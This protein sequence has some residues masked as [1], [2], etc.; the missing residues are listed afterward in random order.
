M[1][2]ASRSSTLLHELTVYRVSK[3]DVTK[4]EPPQVYFKPL[5]RP[6]E[7]KHLKKKEQQEAL[8][9]NLN[10][11]VHMIAHRR[12]GAGPIP[13]RSELAYSSGLRQ[14]A[15]PQSALN[16]SHG[17]RRFTLVAGN[18]NRGSFLS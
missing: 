11:V 14:Y 1:K 8:K 3:D 12:S 18:S 17:Q 4:A 7:D 13:T 16:S 10:E 5:N 6:A 15:R 9:G 2:V